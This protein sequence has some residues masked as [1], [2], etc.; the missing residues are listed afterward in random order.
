M[1]KN[2]VQ[3]VF[4]AVLCLFLLS[5]ACLGGQQASAEESRTEMSAADIYEQNVNSTVG[6]TTTVTTTNIW[7]YQTTTPVAGSGFLITEDGYVLTNY[8]VIE[9]AEDVTVTLYDGTT[10]DGEITGYD[11]SNDIAVLKVDAEGLDPVT[12][13]DSNSLRVGDGVLAIGNPLGELTFSLTG[14]MIS[15]LDREITVSSGMT[16]DLIQTDCAINSGN[17]G[18]ALFNMYGE[19]IGITNAK[20]S[21]GSSSEASVD[22][23]GFAIPI[24]R[25]YSIVESIMHDGV[26]AKP[27][28]GVTVSDVGSEALAYGLPRGAS[29]HSVT[30]GSPAEESGL[31]ENDIITAYDGREITGRRDLSNVIAASQVDSEHTLTVYRQGETMEL[32]VKIGQTEEPALPEE[33][34]EVKTEDGSVEWGPWYP[35]N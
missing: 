25:V 3:K 4:A 22:N 10:Y 26:I 1:S 30:E 23:I 6:I 7:G 35:R 18:G 21:S 32:T 27:Y 13:G 20:Y 24:S 2:I 11:E 16:M 31:Q 5:T 15:A 8:H 14:G 28:I 29:V 19:V 34:P 9:G 17:S 33:E 12:I